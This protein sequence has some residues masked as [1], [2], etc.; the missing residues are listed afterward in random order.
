MRI[1]DFTYSGP[2][3]FGNSQGQCLGEEEADLER[4]R[5]GV[6]LEEKQQAVWG[7]LTSIPEEGLSQLHSVRGFCAFRKTLYTDPEECG[8][9]HHSMLNAWPW[10]FL[11]TQQTNFRKQDGRRETGTERSKMSLS[12]PCCS[13]PG[14]HGNKAM[15]H[16]VYEMETI[17]L[18]D[19]RKAFG[20]AD[21]SLLRGG[22]GKD[23]GRAAQTPFSQ[24]GA[25][26]IPNEAQSQSTEGQVPGSALLVNQNARTSGFQKTNW[27]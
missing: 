7:P 25:C 27:S 9:V 20:I 21:I 5:E 1:A 12:G 22:R 19:K 6:G 3:D 10:C 23:P 26:I 16:G 4:K 17:I 14:D 2:M 24:E 18:A 13:R 15:V 8:F 11:V